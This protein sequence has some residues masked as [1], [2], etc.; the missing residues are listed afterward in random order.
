L[1]SEDCRNDHRYT[2]EIIDLKV[3]DS[4]AYS[5]IKRVE[6]TRENEMSAEN[7]AHI[8]KQTPEFL[9]KLSVLV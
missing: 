7:T 3:R 8:D 4:L 5:E 2:S 1:N 9:L 6:R